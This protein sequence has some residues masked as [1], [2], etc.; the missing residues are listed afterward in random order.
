MRAFANA[1]SAF[2]GHIDERDRSGSCAIVVL[3]VADM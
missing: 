1:E 3:I 2:L